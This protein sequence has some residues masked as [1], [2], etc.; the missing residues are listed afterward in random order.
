[1]RCRRRCCGS[2]ARLPRPARR[3]RRR[4][5][6]DA[7]TRGAQHYLR[8]LGIDVWVPRAGAA[9]VQSAARAAAPGAPPAPAAAHRRRQSAGVP[10][11]D[12]EIA[13]HWQALQAEVAAC[14]RCALHTTR[15]QT[16]FG[17]GDARADWLV[18]GEAPGADEDRQG[19]PFVGPRRPAAECDAAGHRPA[20]ARASTS[21]TS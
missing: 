10:Y 7:W 19:E 1:M 12:L 5:S 18:I 11:L 20:R 16:V 3:A 21:R 4:S 2:R 8:T 14:T 17:V 6:A 9:P 15:T 13:A